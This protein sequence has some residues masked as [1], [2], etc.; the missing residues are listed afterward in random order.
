MFTLGGT[1]AVPPLYLKLHSSLPLTFQGGIILF[2]QC[3]LLEDF[4]GQQ[5]IIFITLN[6]H[7]TSAGEIHLINSSLT[8]VKLRQV[9]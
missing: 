5:L 7:N 4:K 2:M 3:L 1:I 8:N 6:L 9:G